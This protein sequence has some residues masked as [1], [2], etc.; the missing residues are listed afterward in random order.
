MAEAGTSVNIIVKATNQSVEDQTIECGIDWTVKRL[1]QHLCDV[2]PTKPAVG[3]QRLIYAGQLL[4][5]NIPLRDYLR[6]YDEDGIHTIHLVCSNP[7]D[8]FHTS[9]TSSTSMGSTSQQPPASQQGLR[10]RNVNQVPQNTVPL[11]APSY[12]YNQAMMYPQAIQAM[13]WT[14]LNPEQLAWMQQTYS[15][16]MTQYLQQYSQG[17]A[18]LQPT[19]PVTPA[20]LPVPE[21]VQRNPDPPA[22]EN[23]QMNAQGGPVN[24][25]EDDG[26]NRDW[27]D[28]F[29]VV[30]RVSILFSVVYFYSS[31][32]RLL[33]VTSLAAIFYLY[34][35]GWFR[36]QP[37]VNRPAQGA[38]P[39]APPR[40]PQAAQDQAI[41]AVPDQQVE[42]GAAVEAENQQE[43]EGGIGL[44]WTFIST[45]FS[46]LVPEQGQQEA[47]N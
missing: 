36:V 22:N 8:V 33:M 23:V 32:S 7:K 6:S 45:F 21:P 40:E 42:G 3:D 26:G 28:W 1:K 14:S 24:E 25:E 2:H 38:Q 34:H 31:L 18:P 11:T 10:H 46:S 43:V 19:V 30:T 29:Y 27:L 5:D 4:T 9:T 17:T 41:P 47:G 12:M 37:R 44:V 20:P 16:F 13:P 35:V 39:A 15:Q